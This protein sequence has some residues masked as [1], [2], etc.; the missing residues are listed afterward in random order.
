VEPLNCNGWRIYF[1]PLF[2]AQYDD[3]VATVS[4]NRSKLSYEEFKSKETTQR[5]KVVKNAIEKSIPED[6]FNLDFTLKDD[7]EGFCRLKRKGLDKRY[8]LFFKAFAQEK[9]IF[10]MWLGYP[11]KEGDKKDCYRVFK[12]MVDSGKLPTSLEAFLEDC[13]LG[14]EGAED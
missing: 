3:L 10:I 8:R 2:K 9:T 1:L 6:P 11:R 13:G 7:L 4:K 12:N 5:L 14:D